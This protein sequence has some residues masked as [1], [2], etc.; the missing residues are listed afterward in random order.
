MLGN[1][2][3]KK[4][5]TEIKITKD[6]KEL[7][8]ARLGVLPSNQVAISLVKGNTCEKASESSRKFFL[9]NIQKLLSSEA[10]LESNQYAKF[11]WWNMKCQVC[12]GDGES[13]F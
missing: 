4:K 11:L 8:K 13:K 12:L 6:I 2:K 3:T 7:V 10:L 9:R 1:K 5:S